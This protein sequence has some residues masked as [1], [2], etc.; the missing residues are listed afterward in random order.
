MESEAVI[1]LTLFLGLFALFAA[2][3]AWWPKRA[4]VQ[5]R[6]SRWLTNWS[7]VVID[8][9]LLRLFAVAAPLLAIGAAID[10]GRLGWG[11]FNQIALP[12]WLEIVLAVAILDLAIWAQH[13]AMHKVP[14]L[15]RLHRVHHA[16]RDMDV[17]TAIR[18]HPL[19]IAVSIAIKI[20][21]V[22]ALGPAALAVL[23][24][25]IVL[26]GTAMFSHANLALPARVERALRWV[27]VTPDMHRIH[28]SVDRV[29]HDTNYGFALSVWDRLFS[30][31]TADP[32]AGHQGMTVGLRWQ[33]DRP[34][35]LGW[36]LRLPFRPL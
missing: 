7:L 18:F 13:V 8:T 17:T 19:E 31:Y 2:L 1:R 20:A 30:T 22:Y 9:A 10:A 36:S 11:L 28:H 29:E 14:L 16:D 25:E 26:N 12:Q 21:L 5:P 27:L 35:R 15:W 33:D 32:A 6:Q 34:A 24:F 4:R 23:I 3:E